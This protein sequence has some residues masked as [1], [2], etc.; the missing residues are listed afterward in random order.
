[1][2]R[3][4]SIISLLFRANERPFG[5][6]WQEWTT[7]WWKWF[8]AI[9]KENSPANDITGDRCAICQNYPDVW[10]L[11][12]T[13]GGRAERTIKIPSGKAVLFP[14]INVT[15][16]DSENPALLHSEN[17]EADMISFVKSNT[18]D[19]VKKHASIDGEDIEI[20][21]EFRVLTP[22]FYFF[23]PPNNIF[24]AQAGLSRGAG[25][26][27]WIFM[28]PLQAGKHS[29]KTSASCLSGKIQIDMKVQLIVEDKD[30]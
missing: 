21:D 3:S 2:K 18:D 15:T 8:L 4:S 17:L 19:I 11:A 5:L 14:V 16:S 28:K 30:P 9:P 10:F 24:G 27:Y 29:I 13:I 20:S 1:M 7:S 26:G 22:P 23:Y 12:G 25:D 6:T